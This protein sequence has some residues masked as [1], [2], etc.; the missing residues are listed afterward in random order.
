MSARDAQIAA[1]RARP[2]APDRVNPDGSRSIRMKRA[3]NGCGVQLGDATEDEMNRGILGL[4][5]PDVRRECPTCGPTAPDP[6][7]VPV[8]IVEGDALCTENECD[9]EP[10]DRT[11]DEYCD[12]VAE[13]KVCATHSAFDREGTVTSTAA[14]PCQRWAKGGESR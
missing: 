5:L 11:P 1:G 2:N 6:K 14:W 12:Q 7:C 4:P 8:T 9:H 13:R 3:C 10:D